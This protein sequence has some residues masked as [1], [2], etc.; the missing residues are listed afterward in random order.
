MLL[1]YSTAPASAFLSP[2]AVLLPGSHFVE[3]LHTLVQKTPFTSALLN[4]LRIASVTAV[5]S[6]MVS[7]M[8]GYALAQFQFFGSRMLFRMVIATLTVPYI[9]VTIP[10]FVMMSRVFH[11]ANSWTGVVL[12]TICNSMGVFFM[13]QSFLLLPRELFDYA[14]LEG[15]SELA[16]FTRIA[17]P[18]ALPAMTIVLIITFLQAWNNYLWPLLILSDPESWT[19]PV[20]LGSL[21][22]SLDAVMWGATMVGALL[23]TLPMMIVFVFL[24]RFIVSGIAAANSRK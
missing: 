10:Q 11:L 8:A 3:N 13:R 17:I 16:I 1:T 2:T 24:Q 6:G 18:L 15:V 14:R 21:I 9:V 23:M 7:C 5:I 4:S 20:A 22:G 19:A 12:P